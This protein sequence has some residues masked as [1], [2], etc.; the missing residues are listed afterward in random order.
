MH[1]TTS[2]I[3][4]QSVPFCYISLVDIKYP[5]TIAPL[6]SLAR[7]SPMNNRH[8]RVK[9]LWPVAAA[10]NKFAFEIGSRRVGGTSFRVWP[11]ES[12]STVEDHIAPAQG[13]NGDGCPIIPKRSLATL[14]FS[15]F[16]R[17]FCVYLTFPDEREFR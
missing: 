5:D 3:A 12:F 11:D 7:M 6:V 16:S 13:R 1:A 4:A 10:E 14:W 9:N 2:G 8:L 17:S 15:N